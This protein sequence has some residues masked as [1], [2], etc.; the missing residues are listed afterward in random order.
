M[1]HY[2]Y[3]TEG[4]ILG[5]AN[6]GESNRYYHIF[7][8]DLGLVMAFAQGVRELKSK[9]RYH[10]RDFF[11]ISLGLIRGKDTWRVT[12][13]DTHTNFENIFRAEDKLALFT[14]I[15]Q[16]LKRFLRGEERNEK[17]F[18]ALV[19]GLCFLEKETFTKNELNNLEL[20][21][22][23]RS[24]NRLGYW[25]GNGET[26]KL[27]ESNLDKLLLEKITTLRPIILREVNRALKESQL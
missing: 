1:S 3:Q 9:L 26:K 14:S 6:S 10:L 7:T 16:F 4:I 25:G 21:L 20:L 15:A 27:L 8:K 17:L 11:Y 2:L 5:S 12:S 19:L 24:L 13:A 23:A 18:E 22:V